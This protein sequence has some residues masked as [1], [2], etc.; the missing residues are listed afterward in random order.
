MIDES[1]I[2]SLGLADAE[3]DAMLK[4][5]VATDRKAAPPPTHKKV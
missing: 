3:L 1:L 2:A 4:G 5:V